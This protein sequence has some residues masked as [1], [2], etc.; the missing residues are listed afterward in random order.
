MKKLDETLSQLLIGIGIFEVIALVAGV[1]FVESPIKYLI[2][3]LI[4]S[5]L[6]F[7]CAYHMWYTLDKN[8]T[9]NA[10]NENG[11]KA[12]SIKNSMV[13]YGVILIVFGI[14]C[15]TDFAYPL[16]AFLGIMGLK[17]GA[18]IQPLVVK[19]KNK[20]SK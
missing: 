7:G 18:Y 1:F 10:D 12:Y 11:A 16:A 4:G 19:F 2:G 9:I 6:A 5:L 3:M 20:S 14:V 15:V 13:R 17:A 8:L